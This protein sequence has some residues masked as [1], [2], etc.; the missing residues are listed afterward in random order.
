[1]TLQQL[2]KILEDLTINK[3]YGKIEISI[4][5]GNIV[6]IRKTETIKLG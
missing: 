3:F 5:H 1:M 4:E 6:L 2:T